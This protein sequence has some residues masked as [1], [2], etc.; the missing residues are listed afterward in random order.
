MEGA[1]CFADP[2]CNNAGLVLPVA[3]YD[4]GQGCS[5]SGGVVYRGAEFPSFQGTYVYGDF[6]SGRIWGLRKAGTTWENTL[7]ADTTHQISAFGEDEAGNLY[8][9][10]YGTGTVYR[11]APM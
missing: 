3:E 10:A 6:C 9:V 5:V 11:I 7:L 2:S 1:H 8:A 4:H